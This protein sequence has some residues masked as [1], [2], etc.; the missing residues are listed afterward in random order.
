MST[1]GTALPSGY[2][3]MG[4]RFVG[5]VASTFVM[6]AS[7]LV[8]E[9]L[10]ISGRGSLTAIH[11]AGAGIWHHGLGSRGF[12]QCWRLA[13]IVGSGLGC[14]V[15]RAGARLFAVLLGGTFMETALD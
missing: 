1:A 2:A 3:A 14:N 7:T 5:G 10:S 15:D 13:R 9:R 11:F 12:P 8:L 4:L 6:C